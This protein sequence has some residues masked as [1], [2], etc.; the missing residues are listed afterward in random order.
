MPARN[1]DLV[2]FSRAV[3][4]KPAGSGATVG[5]PGEE[6]ITGDFSSGGVREIRRI[7]RRGAFPEK[8]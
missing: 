4:Q 2:L 7:F 6:L 8:L 3:T 5:F 1:S